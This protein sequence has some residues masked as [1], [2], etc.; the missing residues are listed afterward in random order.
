MSSFK[1]KII[2]AGSKL[3]TDSL[4]QRLEIKRRVPAR[5]TVGADIWDKD[6]EFRPCEIAALSIWD[7]SNQQRFEF[8]RSTFYKGAVGALLVFD[9]TREETYI[10]TKKWLAE[11]RQFA[12]EKIPFLLIGTNVH[13]LEEGK[14]IIDRSEVRLCAEKEGGIYIEA[15]P[16]TIANI[17]EALKELTR[18][19]IDSRT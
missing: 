10:E 7:I 18:K 13:L 19:I 2:L 17:D 5:L 14:E 8:I 11:I 6:V 15:S 3:I 16:E 12:G 9:L 4:L 1:L